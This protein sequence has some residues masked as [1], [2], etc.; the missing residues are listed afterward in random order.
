ML[1]NI[2]YPSETHLKL[3]SHKISFVH[4][5]CLS[6]PIVFCTEH[7][8]DTAMLR[9]KFQAN[10]IIETDVMDEQ[11]SVRFLFKMSFGGIYYIAHHPGI[12]SSLH[13]SWDL[14]T[15]LFKCFFMCS[16][17]HGCRHPGGSWCCQDIS[18]TVTYY[19][20]LIARFMGPTWGPPGSCQAQVGPM[21]APWTLLSGCSAII[22][23]SVFSN[24][25]KR[26]TP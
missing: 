6:C 9:A 7:G 12:S 11:V 24:I 5:I 21:L 14:H 15:L 17:Y 10:W 26:D 20:A 4:N 1:C 3:T 8:T 23:R 16:Q 19:R 22:T 2:G 13:M 25:F 18:R